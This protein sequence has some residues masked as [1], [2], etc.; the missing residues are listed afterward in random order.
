MNLGWVGGE[1]EAEHDTQHMQGWR[2]ELKE[3]PED[4]FGGRPTAIDS[5]DE[6]DSV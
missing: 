6:T 4:A 5:R 1:A 2:T 3:M